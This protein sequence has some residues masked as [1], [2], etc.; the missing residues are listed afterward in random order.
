[1]SS[2]TDFRRKYLFTGL[3]ITWH[4]CLTAGDVKLNDMFDLRFLSDF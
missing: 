2:L 1:M 3:H 4:G